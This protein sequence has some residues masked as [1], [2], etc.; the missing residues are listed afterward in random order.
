MDRIDK[1]W[2]HKDI[3]V[4]AGAYVVSRLSINSGGG[5]SLQLHKEKVETLIVESGYCLISVD[6]TS[7]KCGPTDYIHIPAGVTHRVEA[8]EG[9]CKII[10]V[11]TSEFDEVVRLKD[12]YGRVGLP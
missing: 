9:G 11:A 10:E 2:G 7:K 3:L 6:K 8:L 12:D 5:L 4:R 1:P